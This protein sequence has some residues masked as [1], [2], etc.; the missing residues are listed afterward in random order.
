[1]RIL[2]L[3]LLFVITFLLSGIDI[4]YAI[5]EASVKRIATSLSE[6]FVPL[7]VKVVKVEGDSAIL[8]GGIEKGIKVGMVLSVSRGGYPFYHPITGTFIGYAEKNIGFAQVYFVG[9][10]YSMAKLYTREPAKSGDIMRVTESKVPLYLFPPVNQ[11]VPGFNILAFYAKLKDELTATGRFNIYSDESTFH[12]ASRGIVDPAF[13]ARYVK[14]YSSYPEPVYCLL[15]WVYEK[16]GDYIFNGTLLSLNT[17]KKVRDFMFVLGK[18]REFEEVTLEKDIIAVSP[19][20][21]NKALAVC[22]GHVENDKVVNVIVVTDERITMYRIEGDRFIPTFDDTHASVFYPY[23]CDTADID[24]DG[25]DEIILS[26]ADLSGFTIESNI[27]KFTGRGFKLIRKS[28]DFVRF[29][30]V[31]GKYFGLGQILLSEDPFAEPVYTVNVKGASITK[32][33]SLEFLKGLLLMG[34][35][36]VS[37]GDRLYFLTNNEGRVVLRDRSGNILNDIIGQYGNRGDAFFYKEPKERRYY[38]TLVSGIPSKDEYATYKDYTLTVPGRGVLLKSRGTYYLALFR[39][40]PF[41]WGAFFDS[42]SAGTIRIYKWNGS[43]FEDVG[44]ER[45][46]PEGIID[47]YSFDIY[48]DGNDELIVLTTKR[49]RGGKKESAYIT[50][51]YIYRIK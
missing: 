46:L 40:N 20:I 31:G 19:F 32:G 43:F 14:K 23:S 11:N 48:G 41:Q 6:Y 3:I 47:L 34:V 4:L 12:F 7:E 16:S 5:D 21:E 15:G 36:V 33:E 9:N 2:K 1:M 10:G 37:I 45:V 8:D 30:R 13:V 24:G 17:G 44:Y 26:G 27:L 49:L 25:R 42:Y 51:V 39:N 38:Y 28:N 22:A 50:R 18:K 35:E 29:Y